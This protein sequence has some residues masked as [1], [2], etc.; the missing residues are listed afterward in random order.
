MGICR[1]QPGGLPPLVDNEPR[2]QWGRRCLGNMHPPDCTLMQ[3]RS[4]CRRGGVHQFSRTW[5]ERT[6]VGR[7]EAGRGPIVYGPSRHQRQWTGTLG[8]CRQMFYC[9]PAGI[10]HMDRDGVISVLH[11]L[12][13]T[14]DKQELHEPRPLI[15]R[16]RNRCR[17]ARITARPRASYP[18]DAYL[19]RTWRGRPDDIAKLP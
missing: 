8:R 11:R 19:G 17:P 7:S 14:P 16:D 1:P 5:P 3:T 12:K 2:R 9:R 13:S 18:A 6:R 4:R 10:L 15:A